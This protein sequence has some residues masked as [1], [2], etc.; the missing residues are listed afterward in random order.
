MERDNRRWTVYGCL[1]AVFNLTRNVWLVNRCIDGASYMD[2]VANGIERARH[3]IFIT[4]WWLS[5]EI[6]LK[7]P[8]GGDSWRLDYMLKKKAVSFRL[9]KKYK[10]FHSFKSV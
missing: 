1:S 4:D 10:I 7:R 5:P 3:E 8:S 2:A 6:F 9:R